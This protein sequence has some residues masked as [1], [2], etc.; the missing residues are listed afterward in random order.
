MLKAH[1]TAKYSNSQQAAKNLNTEFKIQ[2]VWESRHKNPSTEGMTQSEHRGTYCAR[3]PAGGP[4]I[5]R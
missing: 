2:S 4:D 5:R 3:G 1:E